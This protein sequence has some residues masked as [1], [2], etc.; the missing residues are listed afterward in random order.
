MI[1]CVI[2]NHGLMKKILVL[3][4]VSVLSLHA[5]PQNRLVKYQGEVSVGYAFGIGKIDSNKA[6]LQIVNG[7]RSENILRS[8]LVWVGIAEAN[9]HGACLLSAI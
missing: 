2:N 7:V 1:K 4:V 3:T 8:G 9:M 5:F 6:S